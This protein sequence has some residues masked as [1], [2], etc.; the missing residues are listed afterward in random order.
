MEKKTR[1]LLN[2]Y[3]K[4][5]NVN[6]EDRYENAHCCGLSDRQCANICCVS[7]CTSCCNAICRS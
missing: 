7:A 3:N 2:E 6:K 5:V 4:Q 1:E